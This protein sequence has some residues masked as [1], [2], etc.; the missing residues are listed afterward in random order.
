[1][2]RYV[3]G[4]T[5]TLHQEVTVHDVD[6]ATPEITF[7]WKM[8]RDG[9]EATITPTLISTGVYEVTVTPLTGGDLYYRWDTEGTLDTAQEGRLSIKE[10]AFTL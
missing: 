2:P 6:T 8:G 3:A 4:T 9:V 7:K 10:S 1:M 5:I